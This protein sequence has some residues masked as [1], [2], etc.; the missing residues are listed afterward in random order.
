[1]QKCDLLEP[2]TNMRVIKLSKIKF[3]NKCAFKE[4]FD[5]MINYIKHKMKCL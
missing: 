1:M 3:D 2:I 5:N 4:C